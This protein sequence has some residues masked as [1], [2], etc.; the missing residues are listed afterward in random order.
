MHVQFWGAARTVTG[1]MHMVVVGNKR[2]LLDCGLYQGN[3]KEA[4]QR[5]KDLP[6]SGKEIDAVVLSHAHI[7][8][9]GN[10]PS[11]VKNG[12][13]RP[14]FSTPVT[15][16][17]ASLML[18]DSAGIQESDIKYVNK[19]RI[20]DGKEPLTPLY[21]TPD[22]VRTMRLFRSVGFHSWFDVVP[23]IKC[24]FHVAGHMLGA[25]IVELQLTEN[26][27]VVN[28]LFSGDLG[29]PARPILRDPE[30]VSSADYLIMEATYGDRLHPAED[31]ADEVLIRLVRRTIAQRGKLI[32]PAFAVGR[33]QEIV[34][35]LNLL[36]EAKKIDPIKVFVDSPM[37]VDATEIFRANADSFDE[38]V[39][40]QLLDEDDG[41][42]FHFKNLALIRKS[43]DS[44]RLNDFNEPCIIIS[45]SGMCESGRIVHHLKNNIEDSKNTILFS[46]YQ[47]ENTTGRH[48]VDGNP[49]VKFFGQVYQ[50][51]ANVEKLLGSS[52][53]ADQ[54]ELLSW[55]KGVCDQGRVQKIALVHCEMNPATALKQ[56]MLEQ[57]FP[58]VII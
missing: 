35:R 32:I 16:E 42:P 40:K 24:R 18:L 28:L 29:R 14:I 9:C 4:Y 36:V 22:A 41:D 51:R 19:K 45:A 37:A 46:G 10:L 26:G 11:L 7:D 5:N 58:D 56:T 54:S 52:G 55:A 48:I 39:A 20:R 33:T 34:Y 53:H 12:F 38:E 47:A 6:F 15:R 2:I 17:L 30:S 50:V 44:K 49:T 57:Q 25:A 27:K 13:S 8:H 31:D 23:G 43:E 3:R 21:T 1:S